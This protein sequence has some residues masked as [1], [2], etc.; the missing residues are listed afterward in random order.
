MSNVRSLPPCIP[1]GGQASNFP[2]RKGHCERPSRIM[3]GER[4]EQLRTGLGPWPC[5][6]ALQ[7]L[8]AY[9]LHALTPP[10]PH[11]LTSAFLPNTALCLA[12]CG[13]WSA[14]S[15]RGRHRHYTKNPTNGS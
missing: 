8:L 7:D 5:T 11:S 10:S 15:M 13:P 4:K 9:L 1:S 2:F 6:R 12:G 14:N 3:A